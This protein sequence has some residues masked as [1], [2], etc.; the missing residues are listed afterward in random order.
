MFGTFSS[1]RTTS[2]ST[3]SVL[4]LLLSCFS[5]QAAQNSLGNDF[6]DLIGIIHTKQSYKSDSYSRANRIH[7]QSHK[8]YVKKSKFNPQSSDIFQASCSMVCSTRF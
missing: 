7:V 6:I 4:Q 3:D 1:M 5:N 2:S 8:R